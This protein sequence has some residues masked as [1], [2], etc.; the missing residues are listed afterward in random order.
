[1]ASEKE[2]YAVGDHE[3]QDWEEGL[4]DDDAWEECDDESPVPV[5]CLFCQQTFPAAESVFEHCKTCH[6]FDIFQLRNTLNLDCFSY[7]KL[8]NFIRSHK[9]LPGD[10]TT[11][12]ISGQASW[13]DDAYMKP[14]L[15]EDQLLQYDIEDSEC[16]W[17]EPSLPE[18]SGEKDSNS[19]K[20]LMEKLRWREAQVEQLEIDLQQAA[21]TVEKMR[22]S[23]KEFLI[24]APEVPVSQNAIESLQEDED[25]AYF[26]SYGHFSIHEE[27]LKDKVRTESYRDCMYKNTDLFKGKVVLD[28]GCGTGILSMF[29]AKAG[30]RRVIGID[31]SDIICQAIDIVRE[32][33][34]EDVIT[35]IKGKVEDVD[36]P[37]KE[38]DI[39]ISEWM[40]YFLL[41]ESMLD[42]VLY[43]RDKWLSPGGSVLPSHCNISL[44]GLRDESLYR[45]HVAYWDDV[46]G[47]KMSCMKVAV[48]REA[49]VEVVNKDSVL[50]TAC[51]VKDIDIEKCTVKEL[52]FS[53]PF[54]LEA[55]SD[56][57]LTAI[58]G[59]FDIFFNSGC[60]NKVMF[61]TSPSDTATHWKQTVFLLQTPVNVEKNQRLEG[62]VS[63]KKNRRD[64]RSL[65]VTINLEGK[66]TT[67]LMQ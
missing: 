59:Y 11:M 15:D 22:N 30:A 50:T 1:M 21:K 26:S 48:M 61:S 57:E 13:N 54:S 63:C 34:M 47:F 52:D 31:Q 36:I 18:I 53:S 5:L 40:G 23:A 60:Q 35:L 2:Y 25:E 38:V 29:A 4:G 14:V 44:A 27:M 41:F 12:Y 62:S 39:I 32:N 55:T 28:I 8:V 66:T 20:L 67:Y 58:V 24:S 49:S 64:P 6:M 33:G 46:Y 16:P 56:G 37:E 51:V 45:K 9:P 19:A 10:I 17:E 3:D 65:I 7:I 42:T 43:A